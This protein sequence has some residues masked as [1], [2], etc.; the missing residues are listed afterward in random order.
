MK[1]Q[2]VTNRNGETQRGYKC[3]SCCEIFD[4][5]DY[6]YHD[7]AISVDEVKEI[8]YNSYVLDR[9]YRICEDLWECNNG[10]L[11]TSSFDIGDLWECGKCEE[12]FVDK[13]EAIGCC[14]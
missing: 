6:T 7:D 1:A 14:Q 12:Q 13:D 5:D 4:E 9:D 2:R 3:L 11:Q 10:C 8:G